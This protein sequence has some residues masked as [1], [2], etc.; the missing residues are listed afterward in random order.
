M[1]LKAESKNETISELVDVIDRHHHIADKSRALQAVLDREKT[2]STGMQY[3]LAI[4]HARVDEVK[5]ITV[6][7]GFKKTGIDFQALDNQP[8]RVIIL[9]LSP[10]LEQ[11]PHIQLLAGIV[12]SLNKQDKVEK[13]LS[14]RNRR[15]VMRFFQPREIGKKGNGMFRRRRAKKAAGVKRAP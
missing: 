2:M 10:V 5:S 1:D 11:S 8:S 12:S 9:I 15:E 7:I 14:C 13:L 4:P 6:A 3:G